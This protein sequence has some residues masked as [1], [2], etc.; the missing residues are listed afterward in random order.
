MLKK[1]YIP[2]LF[3]FFF[4]LIVKIFYLLIYTREFSF[5]VTGLT[6]FNYY[7]TLSFSIDMQAFRDANHP[8]T[9]IYF[10][11]YLILLITGNKISNFNEYY[12]LHYIF[13]FVFNLF[14]INIFINYF[15]KILNWYE[16][17]FFLTIFFSSFNFIFGLEIVSLISYQFAITILLIT[18]YLKSIEK[19]KFVKLGIIC[20]FAISM[21][22]TFLPFVLSIFIS[23]SIYILLLNKLKIIRLIKFYFSFIIFYLIFNFPIL[24]RIPKIFIDVLF[25]RKDASLSMS[26]ESL[27]NGFKN[28]LNIVYE[29]NQIFLF[30]LIFFFILFIFNIFKCFKINNIKEKK[31]HFTIMIFNVLI[32]FFYIY[33]FIIAGQ[34][35]SLNYEFEVL[36]KENYF[37]NNFP[38]L[39][40]IFLNYY[41]YKK[42]LNMR[43]FNDVVAIFLSFLLITLGIYNYN[44]S[45]EINIKDKIDRRKILN[46]KLSEYIDVKKSI[47]AYNVY[48]TGYGFGD[49]IF[50]FSGNSLEGNE[51]FTEEIIKLFPNYRHLR[52]NDIYRQ[53]QDLEHTKK[54]QINDV[55]KF[56][57]KIKPLDDYLKKNLSQ[58][59]YEILSYKSKNSSFNNLI[60]RSDEIYTY[61]NN[62]NFAK[63]NVL[64]FTNKKINKTGFI[65]ENE[66][67]DAIKKQ[68]DIKKRLSFNVK[69]DVWYLY[70]IKN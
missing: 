34:I 63:A 65:S 45:R 44:I 55:S 35:Y 66:I 25:L 31:D 48:S 69:N 26:K 47:I 53:I 16:I 6:K 38:Y 12:Y 62:N 19:K 42:H 36:E 46:L 9:P 70:L 37:R 7:N 18:Y 20:A 29:Q 40:F 23:S 64:L 2:F 61:Q 4:I 54:D 14:S 41:V 67:Y 39:I 49:E 68:L 30:L 13:I 21:K 27:V 43:S 51:Y 10:I 28:S 8:G 11:G 50:H 58:S 5:L 3:V 56:K 22:M 1:K 32:T 59:I 15:R 60:K 57:N 33:T 52:M 24:G 17:L